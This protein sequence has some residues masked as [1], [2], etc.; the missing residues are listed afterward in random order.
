MIKTLLLIKNMNDISDVNSLWN[1]FVS[2]FLTSIDQ[3]VPLR[4]YQPKP[5]FIKGRYHLYKEVNQKA[6]KLP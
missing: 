4:F 3:F 5:K 6:F 2:N 1:S